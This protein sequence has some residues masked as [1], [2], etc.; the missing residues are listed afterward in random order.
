MVPFTVSALAEFTVQVWLEPRRTL[1]LITCAPVPAAVVIPAPMM[2][3]VLPEI[4]TAPVAPARKFNSAIVRSV[5]SVVAKGALVPVVLKYT[6]VKAPG[7]PP[8]G[9]EP[10]ASLN[11]FVLVSHE[12]LVAPFQ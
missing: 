1:L 11:Q 10:P 9:V 5:S 2:V 8:R 12:V 7:I 4:E 6:L 3:R